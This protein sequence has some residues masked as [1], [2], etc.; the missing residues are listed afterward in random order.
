MSK[1]RVSMLAAVTA[2]A[3]GLCGIST[4][5]AV[6]ANGIAISHITPPWGVQKAGYYRRGYYR[7]YRRYHRRYYR[8]Y[9]DYYAYYP[10]YRRYYGYYR[11]YYYQPYYYNRLYYRRYY[12]W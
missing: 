10:P 3:F 12:Y 7:P 2:I 8:H 11:P 4:A 5:S 1:V 9:P 6:P